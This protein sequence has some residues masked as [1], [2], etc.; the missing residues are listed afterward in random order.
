MKSDVPPC[1]TNGKVIPDRGS[2][3]SMAPMFTNAWAVIIIT[4]PTIMSLPNG[5]EIL[6]AIFSPRV[7]KNTKRIMSTVAPVNPNSSASTA[8]IESPIGSGKK[9]N[10]WTLW[11]NPRPNIPPDPM[12]IKDCWI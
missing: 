9:L 6:E 4:S 7:A 3:P 2:T 1:D 12:A 10:F 5:S 11:P 8:K